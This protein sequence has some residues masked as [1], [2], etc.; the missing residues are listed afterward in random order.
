MD[1]VAKEY[2]NG[3][4]TVVWKPDLCIHSKICWEGLP[5]VFTPE[6]RPWVNINGANTGRIIEQVEKC[7]SA[8]LSYYMNN[9][10]L[11]NKQQEIDS[12]I[13]ADIM[14]D[15]P[16]IVHGDICL[17][18]KDGKILPKKNPTI[19]CRCGYSGNK[20]YCD[21]SHVDMKFKD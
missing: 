10:K 2:S 11:Q 14:K 8:A 13:E 20:P 16:I 21:G 18:D 17:K 5:E 12:N 3:E 9:E 7:P 19:L 15:G 6:K 4:V 1:K